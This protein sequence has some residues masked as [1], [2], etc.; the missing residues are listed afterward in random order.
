MRYTDVPS[1]AY[2]SG[3]ISTS[4]DWAYPTVAQADAAGRTLTWPRGKVLGGSSAVNGMYWVRPSQLEYE[5]WSALVADQDGASA[6]N[7]T[8]QLDAMKRAETFTAPAS[9]LASANSLE[10]N[11][12]SHGTSGPIHGSWP[13]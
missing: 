2:Y 10:Y 4:Y 9:D 6:W 1:E 11:A 5:A 3:L 8:Y 13:G 12:D 7:W